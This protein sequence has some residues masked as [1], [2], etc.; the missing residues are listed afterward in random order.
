MKNIN[1]LLAIAL[2]GSMTVGCNDLDTEPLGST[3]TSDQKAAVVEANPEMAAAAVFALPQ[4]LKLVMNNYSSIHTDFGVPSMFLITDQRGQDMAAPNAGYNWY[5]AA[6]SMADFGGNYYDN[7]LYWKTYYNEIL[8]ANLVIGSMSDDSENPEIQYFLAQGLTFRA[9]A[10]EA[11]T[12]MYQFTYAKDKTAPCVPIITDENREEAGLNGNPRA[13]VEEMYA[14]VL[15]D[16]D[17]A[18]VLIE[19]AYEAGYTRDDKRFISPCVV[20]GLKARAYLVMTD[21][22]NAAKYAEKAITLANAEGLR[23]YSIAEAGVPAFV[24]LSDPNFMW[25]IQNQASEG[26]TQG[27]VNFAS[28]MGSWMN[29]GYCSTGM[30]RCIN[31]NLYKSIPSTDVRKNWWL[32]TDGSVPST[33]PTAY[34]AYVKQA[35]NFTPCAQVKF[36]AAAAG[37]GQPSGATDVPLMRIEEMY[38][39]LAEAQGMQATATGSKTLSDFVKTYRDPAYSFTATG[40]QAFQDE[41]W[42]QR[43]IELWGEGFSYSD[44]MRLQKGIDRRGGGWDPAWVFVV[45]KDDPVLL[46]EIITAEQQANPA[47]GNTSN[48]AS[49]PQPVDDK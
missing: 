25:G 45:A 41:V 22:A 6:A 1:K 18:E 42:H 24:N 49:V 38:L 16:L 35:G 20:A 47:I 23:P 44:M 37:P 7:L 10:Y 36:G 32:G 27:V 8:S 9:Y 15:S 48:G 4:G 39:I 30:Y 2:V 26:F 14:Q 46:Y 34:A 31:Y 28:M 17:R 33:L 21:W 19:K 5:S 29:N 12:Y 11:L 43:R 3:V 13:S 40:T